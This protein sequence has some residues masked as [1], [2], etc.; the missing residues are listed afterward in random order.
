M[1]PR[2]EELMVREVQL[3]AENAS[4]AKDGRVKENGE[5]GC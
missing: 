5:R 4:I 3:Q 2:E 1:V